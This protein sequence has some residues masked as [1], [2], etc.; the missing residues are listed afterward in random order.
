[1]TAYEELGF[2]PVRGSFLME[3]SDGLLSHGEEEAQSEERGFSSR[4]LLPPWEL[5]GAAKAMGS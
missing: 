3:L 4:P 1:M 2:S 5:V